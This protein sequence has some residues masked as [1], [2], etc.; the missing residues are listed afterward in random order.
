MNG[1]RQA[2]RKVEA[3]PWVDRLAIVGLITFGVVHLVFAWLAVALA[4]GERKGKASTSG[5]VQE[6]AEKPFGTVLV[7]AVAV[8]MLGLIV[9]QGIEAATGHRREE[10]AK[11]TA[12]RLASAGKALVYLAIGVSAVK[13]ALGS[14]SNEEKKAD[15]LTAQL[16]DLPAGQLLVGAVALAIIGTGVGLFV[17]AYRESYL[18]HMDG[19]G[20]SGH[21]GRLYRWAARLG[22]AAKGVALVIVG[23]LF[24]YAAISHQPKESGG[25]DVALRTVLD[26]PFGPGLLTLIAFGL[27]CYGLFCFAQ[28]RHLD[29]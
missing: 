28:A 3:S 19:E 7:W 2:A 12:K 13:I 6:L 9:W 11:R 18:Q 4:F 23:C 10:G 5:A 8:G 15:S 25:L 24:G 29:R 14:R 17:V 26:Q 21:T 16:M 20:T 27:A 22:H 1:A